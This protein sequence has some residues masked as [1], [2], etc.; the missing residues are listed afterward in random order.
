MPKTVRAVDDPE[1]VIAPG[2]QQV[3]PTGFPATP[4]FG[5]GVAGEPSTFGWPGPTVVAEQNRS[6]LITWTNGLVD[7]DGQFVPHLLPID[8]T[9]H[10]A[11]PAGG[12]LGRDRRPPSPGTSAYV[13]PVPTVMHVHGAHVEADSDGFPEAWFLPDAAN[14]P[15][16]Y[17]RV[18][19]WYD[20]LRKDAKKRTKH[21][22]A[23]G[24]STYQYRNDQSATT[25][26][27]HDHALGLTRAN[28]WAGM[29][30]A[31]II[32][33][34]KG[35]IETT[36]ALPKG[37][38]ELPLIVQ[39][40]SFRTDGTLAYPDSRA[41]FDGYTGPVTG[42]GSASDIA[43]IWN[44][45]VFG[46]VMCV[47]GRAW[48]THP[49]EP[50]R[51]RLRFVNGCDSRTLVLRFD[52]DLPMWQIGNEGGFLPAPVRVNRLLMMPGQRADVIVDF[53]P[54]AGQNVTLLNDG[55]DE[56]FDGDLDSITPAD[57]ETT[58]QVMRFEVA[59]ACTSGDDRSTDPASLP[60]PSIA[61]LPRVDRSRTV[62]LAEYSSQRFNADGTPLDPADPT[63]AAGPICVLLG[64]P[65]ASGKPIGLTWDA[66]PTEMIRKG[67]TEEWVILNYTAD[68]HPIHLHQT[69]FEILGR[70]IDGT[71]MPAPHEAGRTDTVIA[72]P[73]ERTRIRARFDLAGRFVWHCHILEHE[74]N[75]M[76]RPL[77]V[78]DEKDV[79]AVVPSQSVICVIPGVV[80]SPT[81]G[82]KPKPPKKPKPTPKTP[83]PTPKTNLVP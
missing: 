26:W 6:N 19:T 52:N 82:R 62:I 39:D 25:L 43:P 59:A 8:P 50:R 40:R 20:K 33:G 83:E 54:V 4:I 12:V 44:P 80:P 46:D 74:D 22:W 67:D 18:G 73:G 81:G 3:L 70:G 76:M 60:L 27:Y 78:G 57:P 37:A 48:P 16:G 53:V 41:A 71:E 56:P 9:I 65:D 36:D 1:L 47:N 32:R 15:D 49:A 55:P 13:G 79:P 75:E 58:G 38:H 5:V 10:W 72:R 24:S 17:A 34:G 31:W 21:D 68:A 29:A 23:A 69:Q 45:E 42:D 28:V 66:P 14:I 64:V 51:Y 63:N 35:S 30:G 11:N 2:R 61:P 7:A 77:V